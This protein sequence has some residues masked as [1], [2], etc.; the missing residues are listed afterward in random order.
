[1]FENILLEK[2]QV[3]LLYVLVEISRNIPREKRQKFY[4]LQCQNPIVIHPNLEGFEMNAYLGDIEILAGSGLL[5]LSYRDSGDPIFDVTP[6]GFKYYEHMKKLDGQPVQRVETAIRTFLDSENFQ[7]K[8][9]KAYQK[10]IIAETKLWGSDSVKQLTEIGH[11]CR[12]AMQEFITAL[13]DHYQL[14]SV[15][16]DK[17]NTV[18]R[19]KA[20]LDLKKNQVGKT[21][22]PF[23]EALIAYWGTICDLVQRQEHGAQKEGREL[24]WEDG[25]RVVF[26]T[27]VV[28]F[29]I[30][31]I[32]SL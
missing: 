10:W 25:R 18:R 29:E 30:D 5:N 23:I 1:M 7:R 9:T 32:L 21:V 20:V 27:A 8:Y 28:M 19:L 15:D 16:K 13:V 3:E 2:E 6:R 26:Q 11:L 22:E 14:L 12:E 4:Y 31:K 24:V 17:S